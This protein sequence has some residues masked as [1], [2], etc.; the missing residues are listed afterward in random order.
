MADQDLKI[1][2]VA[3]T[4]AAQDALGKLADEMAG[5]AK[6]SGGAGTEQQKLARNVA[7]TTAKVAAAKEA[8]ERVK[9]AQSEASAV[10]QAF[11]RDSREAAEAI[12]RSTAAQEAATK[13]TRNAESAIAASSA[14]VM[15]AGKVADEKGAAAVKR[16]GDSLLK[17]GKD[18]DKAA[19][20]LRTLEAR[21]SSLT[22]MEGEAAA[23]SRAMA[24]E[25]MRLAQA[26]AA[27]AA[28][29]AAVE[30]AANERVTHTLESKVAAAKEAHDAAAA[31]TGRASRALN[32][33][34]S[35]VVRFGRDS[36]QAAQ[37]L[38]KL[39][40]AQEAATE[41][42]KHADRALEAAAKAID[43][44]A[45]S[46]GA[47]ATHDL[48]RLERELLEVGK[49]ADK[50]SLSL[51]DVEARTTAAGKSVQ[52]FSSAAAQ[53]T[54]QVGG[55]GMM[56]GKVGPMMGGA[57]FAGG[58][59]GA[60]GALRDA[61][62][63]AFSF[64]TA[65][66]NLPF[67]LDAARVAT[68]GLVTD[69]QLAQSA[70]QGLALGVIKDEQEFA[71]LSEAATK[72][73]IKLGIG[74]SQALDNMM[75]A[76]GRG[77][78]EILDNLG[79]AMKAS[80]AYDR[81]AKSIGKTADDLTEAEKKVAFKTEAIKA[82]TV[83][84]D[85]TTIQT[86]TA[87]G[88]IQRFGIS[89]DN[90]TAAAK[91]F[92]VEVFGG[93]LLAM[94]KLNHASST[95]RV[96]ERVEAERAYVDEMRALE[97]A[98]LARNAAEAEF[99]RNWHEAHGGLAEMSAA[100]HAAMRAVGQQ[101]FDNA[102]TLGTLDGELLKHWTT[103]KDFTTSLWDQVDA[104]AERTRQTRE[105]A[106][107]DDALWEK[108]SARNEEDSREEMMKRGLG[109]IGPDLPKGFVR[110]NVEKEAKKARKDRNKGLLDR[111][112][113]DNSVSEFTFEVG[114][115]MR[116]EDMKLRAAAF[117][118]ESTL[119]EM[120]LNEMEAA[121]DA[122]EE[123]SFEHIRLVD[124][125]LQADIEYARWQQE[126]AVTDEQRQ[127]AATAVEAA[128]SRKRIALIKR[129]AAEEAAAEKKRLEEM[130]KE[131]K[132]REKITEEVTGAIG[133]LTEGMISAFEA[134]ARGEKGAMAEM[135]ADLLKGVAKKHAILALGEFAQGVGS[136]AATFG[137]VNPK[138][139]AHFA[140]AA[141]HTGVAVAAGVG[142]FAAGQVADARQGTGNYA[143]GGG[144]GG[145]GGSS[146]FG[147]GPGG[148]G[149]SGSNPGASNDEGVQ[150]QETPI[151]HEQLRRENGMVPRSNASAAGPAVQINTVHLYGAGGKA[152]FVEDIRRAID[153]SDRGGKRHRI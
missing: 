29:A 53:N 128:E 46:A 147:P 31:A 6:A 95:E 47:R 111:H 63:Q 126:N 28:R 8:I 85:A 57:L 120:R 83:A 34:I 108:V 52:T 43:H 10:V 74:P 22:Q 99:A 150:A 15:E 113:F 96:N 122:E 106:A 151:S 56:I 54:E 25:A 112:D 2:V 139:A 90:A 110:P 49:A 114:A 115:E 136:T 80:E 81:Y 133:T 37:S 67:G 124:A 93:M 149:A 152:E 59:M 14:A 60:A 19:T 98:T 58:V 97:K 118:Q 148:G 65:M 75:T 82:L 73:G 32:E 104:Y 77:S 89:T 71:R 125:K 42:A 135:L 16:L 107:A 129:V 4:N 109:M 141:L 145:G 131:A 103:V 87:A 33:H 91:G 143:A 68:K 1:R 105:A 121:A 137:I 138:A 78:T 51:R 11:G 12:A 69:M 9:R 144:G 94:E 140:A 116:K 134:M 48:D 132:R 86:D 127:R 5:L 24:A 61:S 123:L 70:A 17:V 88:A 130:E 36:D 45:Q 23:A 146:G 26:E 102:N 117:E 13:A 79:V 21:I 153:R 35:I 76:L 27:A 40:L 62:A 20:D 72:L 100:E 92:A 3:E 84:A 142:A 55:L 66:A 50:T 41:G 30:M 119:R 101:A 44:T 18:A 38:Q 64:E 39:R 7:E